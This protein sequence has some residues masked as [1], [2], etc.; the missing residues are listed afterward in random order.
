MHL[1]INITS[2]TYGRDVEVQS[3]A[4]GEHRLWLF[5]Y[6]YLPCALREAEVALAQE[7][8]PELYVLVHRMHKLAQFWQYSMRQIATQILI[9][10]R[11]V[12]Q[13][14]K[15]W[16]AIHALLVANTVK[17]PWIHEPVSLYCSY[18]AVDMCN[19]KLPLLLGWR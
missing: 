14:C 18:Y 13:Y 11:T 5:R 7:L 4:K 8:N 3:D 19:F 1:V 12:V 16:E 17:F 2:I 9:S 10:A 6:Y 15:N